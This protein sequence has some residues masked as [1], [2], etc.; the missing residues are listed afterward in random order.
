MN[1]KDTTN[2]LALMTN[3]RE[4]VKSWFD[5]RSY[6]EMFEDINANPSVED[7]SFTVDGIKYKVAL[8][9]ENAIWRDGVYPIERRSKEDMEKEKETEIINDELKKRYR[10]VLEIAEKNL[11]D[12]ISVTFDLQKIKEKDEY[13]NSIY[14]RHPRLLYNN[15]ETYLK[16]GTTLTG[17]FEELT[18]IVEAWDVDSGGYLHSG[19][20]TLL[21]WVNTELI[22]NVVSVANNNVSIPSIVVSNDDDDDTTP[23]P[24][25]FKETTEID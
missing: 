1:T 9:T 24:K 3:C 18:D 17:K 6:F 5:D 12:V 4:L 11:N 8:V 13:V 25:K 16:E 7:C 23:E 21:R 2:R 15:A 22:S 14:P 10:K 19:Y 20:H